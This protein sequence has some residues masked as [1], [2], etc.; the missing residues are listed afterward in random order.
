VHILFI[1]SSFGRRLTEITDNT[2]TSPVLTVTEAESILQAGSIMNFILEAGKVRF[3]I[4]LDVAEVSGLK[5]SSKL[6]MLARVF[7]NGRMEN[8]D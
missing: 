5:I 2:Q 6:L 8:G 7:R 3:E 4:N 1:S